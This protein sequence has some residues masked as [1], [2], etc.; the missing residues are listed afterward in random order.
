M[1]GWMHGRIVW[2]DSDH[3]KE[4]INQRMNGAVQSDVI[5]SHDMICVQARCS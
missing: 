4:R 5:G 2:S 1:D 3:K